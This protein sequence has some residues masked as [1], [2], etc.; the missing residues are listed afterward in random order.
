MKRYGQ[1]IPFKAN[2]ATVKMRKKNLQNRHFISKN[3]KK[4]SESPDKLSNFSM[5]L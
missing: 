1:F 5:T 2:E 3:S 4:V